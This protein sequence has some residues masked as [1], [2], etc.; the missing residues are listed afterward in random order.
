[1]FSPQAAKT[2]TQERIDRFCMFL[3]KSMVAEVSQA[4]RDP[5]P[6]G[7][8]LAGKSTGNHGVY[9]EIW[10]GPVIFPLKNPL[11]MA[12][13]FLISWLSSWLSSWFLPI[14]GIRS[15]HREGG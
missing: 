6:Y 11:N 12:W 1:M 15:L 7:I 2:S 9:H 8:G 3:Q 5:E 13:V 4:T 14:F 10:G